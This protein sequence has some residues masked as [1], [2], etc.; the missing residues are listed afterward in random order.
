MPRHLSGSPS[1]AKGGETNGPSAP[2]VST[3]TADVLRDTLNTFIPAEASG[4]ERLRMVTEALR[5]EH[6]AMLRNFM[7]QW[8]VERAVPVRGLVPE[9]YESW[10]PV[11]RD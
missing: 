4:E 9:S 6:G 10:R 11:V 1:V 8:I 3:A 5:G 7:G 2:P